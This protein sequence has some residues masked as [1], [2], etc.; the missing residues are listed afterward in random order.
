[1]ILTLKRTSFVVALL[2]AAGML[3]TAAHARQGAHA[4][5]Q[6]FTVYSA[7][8]DNK[9][10]PLLVQAT[11]RIAAIGTATAKE[12]ARNNM[13]PLT[14]VFPKGK[15]FVTAHDR[16]V[17]KPDPRTC[18][19]TEH[20]SGSYRVTGGTGAY[21]HASGRGRFVERGAAIGARGSDGACLQKFKLNYV[22]ANFTGA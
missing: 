18:T 21:R 4:V 10:T 14:F 3:A 15:V 17:W 13:V 20:S 22:I 8:V 7:N 9:D 16:F 2:T 12:D 11:G 1:M 5:P 6:R 19:A